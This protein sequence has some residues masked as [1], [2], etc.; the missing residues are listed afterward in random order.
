ML[1]VTDNGVK[2]QLQN[3]TAPAMNFAIFPRI[4]ITG[5]LLALVGI[6]LAM[7]LSVGIA[8]VLI[9]AIVAGAIIWQKFLANPRPLLENTM[10]PH[11]ITGGEV[12]ITP[13]QIE[14]ISASNHKSVYPLPQYICFEIEDNQLKISDI[15]NLPLLVISGFQE[16][17][18]AKVTQAVLQGKT[19]QT[20]GKAIKMQ[21]SC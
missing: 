20:Q 19:I 12:L 1:I 11:I 18:H 15:K 16:P 7:G 13:S 14:H 17:Q 21:S 4:V 5:L 10:S 6:G 9:L 2:I 3:S 8:I